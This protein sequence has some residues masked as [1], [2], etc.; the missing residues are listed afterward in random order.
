MKKLYFLR[1]KLVLTV[2]IEMKKYE[3]FGELFVDLKLQLK[4]GKA[5]LAARIYQHKFSFWSAV[6]I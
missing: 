5:P 3:P 4:I 6:S 2:Y 1:Y